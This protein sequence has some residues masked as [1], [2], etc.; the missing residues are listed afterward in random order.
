MNGSL[1]FNPGSLG[2]LETLPRVVTTPTSPAGT[3]NT[4]DSRA[5][6]PMKT[7]V[8]P[9]TVL[10]I[11][12]VWGLAC[13]LMREINIKNISDHLLVVTKKYSVDFLIGDLID[14]SLHL[15][16][17]RFSQ[18]DIAVMAASNSR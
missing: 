5:M 11:C 18:H 16:S 8:M 9:T 10:V 2:V 17:F 3:T 14:L 6:P 7:V 12:S 15:N 4:L 13:I 1:R